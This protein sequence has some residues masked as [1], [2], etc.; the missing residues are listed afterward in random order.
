M[1]DVQAAIDHYHELLD[2]RYARETVERVQEQT[3]RCWLYGEQGD[4]FT[5]V[6]RPRFI[7]SASYAEACRAATLV[8]R[9]FDLAAERLRADRAARRQ[10]GFPGYME[11]FLELDREHG[12][13]GVVNRI[14]ALVTDDGAV[15]FL[16]CNGAPGLITESHELARLFEA[17]PVSR[18]FAERYPYR[19]EPLYELMLDTLVQVHRRRR[20]G[21]GRPHIG[22]LR[23]NL[24]MHQDSYHRWVTWMASR[25]CVVVLA[26]AE[27]FEYRQGRLL[28]AGVP[29]ESI[30]L[31]DW[32]L[33]Y[34]LEREVPPLCQALRDGAVW[35][36]PGLGLSTLKTYKHV[37]AVLTDPRTYPWFEG[38]VARAVRD[39]VPWT[40]VVREGMTEREGERI[41]LLPYIEDHRDQLV[42]KAAGGTGGKQVTLGWTCD[43]AQWREAL[44][45]ALR[46]PAVVQDAVRV[47]PR[48]YPA[49]EPDGKVA[50]HEMYADLAPF[51]RAD[52]PA[53]A[54]AARVSPGPT[55]NT[56]SGAS[57][58]PTWILQ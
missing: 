17:L 22:V 24:R 6:I 12:G 57:S 9:A 50:L 5:T 39:H 52:A 45:R 31:V 18:A 3:E 21:P 34:D 49:M 33:L 23:R 54:G 14:D 42:L 53:V 36:L 30:H 43:E 37:L 41:D 10:L 4:A 2:T 8:S 29:V 48:R 38:E 13:H 27:E 44:R 35:A 58:V 55:L 26:S 47:T 51:V 7:D 15:K 1:T 32:M 46:H 19:V 56:H 28:A 25:G 40:R 11:V 16:E 20:G